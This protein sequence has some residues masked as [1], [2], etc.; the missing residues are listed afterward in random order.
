[1]GGREMSIDIES[2]NLASPF[3]M[4]A[5]PLLKE[6][7]EKLSTLS[8]DTA[9]IYDKLY[10]PLPGLSLRAGDLEQNLSKIVRLRMRLQYLIPATT[11]LARAVSGMIKNGRL[12]DIERMELQ[13]RLAELESLI[14]T[15][16]DQYKKL[17]PSKS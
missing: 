1:M 2:E 9:S 7:T 4:S 15:V 11:D 16:Q 14:M 8:E 13:I 10:H 6:Y 17:Q 5:I 12:T 3:V